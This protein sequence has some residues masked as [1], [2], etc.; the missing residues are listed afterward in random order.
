[1]G[2]G[3]GE[4]ADDAETPVAGEDDDEQRWSGDGEASWDCKKAGRS[5]G[6]SRR[7]YTSLVSRR[8]DT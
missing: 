3:A 6:P 8:S 2:K 7:I 5:S 4:G 1:M